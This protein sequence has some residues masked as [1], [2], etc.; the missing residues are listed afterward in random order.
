LHE[1]EATL[2]PA[3][4]FPDDELNAILAGDDGPVDDG[5]EPDIDH[6]AELQKKWG[7]AR[8]QVWAV[9]N[10]RLMCGDAT[11]ADDVKTL[12]ESKVDCLFT[13][14]PYNVDVPYGEYDDKHMPMKDYVKWLGGICGVW[15][16]FIKDGRA[17]IWNV[18]VSPRTYAFHQFRMLEENGL[19]FVRQ[20]IWKKMGVPVPSW[21]NTEKNPVA[22]QLTSNYIHEFVCV[23]SKGDLQKGESVVFDDI[24]QHDVFT[25]S[26]TSATKD[27]PDG[28]MVS[29]SAGAGLNR[30]KKAHPAVFPVRL[31]SSF[32]QHY[33][34]HGESVAD[35]FVG[36]GTTM[37]A[38]QQLDRR[39]FGMEI[40]PAFCAVALQ[41]MD[42]MGVTGE[43][44][45]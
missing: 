22:R 43:L 27:V 29:G 36:S 41:R 37:V 15:V 30:A 19:T 18:G 38:A 20:F 24:L 34:A 44:I 21:F 13:S 1:I 17:F 32:L 25:I 12:C 28:N 35:P 8:G 16:E 2:L 23:F 9:G 45:K 3:L 11:A 6:A 7:T 5:P 10:H 14:P 39:C 33:T 42:D 26:Q 4:G 31:P 40:D